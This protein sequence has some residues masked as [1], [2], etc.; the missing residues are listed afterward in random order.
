MALYLGEV[1]FS[2]LKVDN[3]V[4]FVTTAVEVLFSNEEEVVLGSVFSVSVV[5]RVDNFGADVPIS[6]MVVV[7]HKLI[8][9]S[10]FASVS[11][12]LVD[13]GI[14]GSDAFDG[15]AEDVVLVFL[16]VGFMNNVD[17]VSLPAELVLLLLVLFRRDTSL[18]I[19]CLLAVSCSNSS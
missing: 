7:F 18:G 3:F 8:V 11:A 19:L 13:P 15:V 10:V 6:M 4:V 5:F 12:V 17:E 1:V 14:S 2:V 16:V 9:I